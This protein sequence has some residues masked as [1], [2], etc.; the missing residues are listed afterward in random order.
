MKRVWVA[1]FIRLLWSIITNIT[2]LTISRIL[3]HTSFV[4]CVYGI[5]VVELAVVRVL[6][7]MALTQPTNHGIISDKIFITLVDER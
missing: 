4:T 1:S 6:L 7:Y 5:V 2:C 3:N